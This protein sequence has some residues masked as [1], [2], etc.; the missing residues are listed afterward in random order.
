M[1][2]IDLSHSFFLKEDHHV[3]YTGNCRLNY[4]ATHEPQLTLSR[5]PD[6]KDEPEPMLVDRITFNKLLQGRLTTKIASF[7]CWKESELGI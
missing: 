2:M 4:I 1:K 3:A 6:C 5:E 7:M